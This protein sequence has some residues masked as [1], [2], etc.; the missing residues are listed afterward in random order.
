MGGLVI[1]WSMFHTKHSVLVCV[2]GFL[3]GVFTSMF[4]YDA[5]H[6]AVY[7]RIFVFFNMI[8]LFAELLVVLKVFW[9]RVRVYDKD[10]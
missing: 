10:A 1:G 9:L 8:V 3:S 6:Y 4:I 7:W 5:M 2:L